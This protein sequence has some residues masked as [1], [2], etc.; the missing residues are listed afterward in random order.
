MQVPKNITHKLWMT[1][2][3]VKWGI[4]L[5]ISVAILGGMLFSCYQGETITTHY[6]NWAGVK[7][8]EAVERGWIPAF[9]PTSST[10]IFE[11]HNIDSNCGVIAFSATPSDLISLAAS[12]EEVPANRFQEIGPCLMS[13]ESWWPSELRNRHLQ[14]LVENGEFKI[15]AK[16]NGSAQEPVNWYFAINRQKG[17]GFAWH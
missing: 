16:T 2:K 11:Q 14:D 8:D 4:A 3:S 15:Y 9:L 17:V 5:T 10:N 7:Q 12:L 1:R 13:K 6:L